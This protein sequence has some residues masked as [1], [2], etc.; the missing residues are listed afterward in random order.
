MASQL[1]LEIKGASACQVMHY[2]STEWVL[3][4]ESM[5]L[6]LKVPRPR[7]SQTTLEPQWQFDANHF[8]LV[9]YHRIT[10]GNV[11]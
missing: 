1:L 10:A 9:A 3:S 4:I 11:N 2:G 7:K 8:S 5:L 6:A